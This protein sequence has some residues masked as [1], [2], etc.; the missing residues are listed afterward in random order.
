MNGFTSENPAVVLTFPHRVPLPCDACTWAYALLG[1][2]VAFVV[3]C[4]LLVLLCLGTW[5]A[6]LIRQ[7]IEHGVF[8]NVP[9]GYF[10]EKIFPRCVFAQRGL[11]PLNGEGAFFMG[12][13]RETLSYSNKLWR[14]YFMCLTL[15][16]HTIPWGLRKFGAVGLVGKAEAC[17]RARRFMGT[18]G[19][20][21]LDIIGGSIR[22]GI[23]HYLEAW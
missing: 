7:C 2:L 15:H 21:W 13:F 10:G 14:G 19:K 16:R 9:L 6:G 18:L 1:V 23:S 20:L 11:P 3:C 17:G 22:L 5:Y 4:G 12:F 8:T